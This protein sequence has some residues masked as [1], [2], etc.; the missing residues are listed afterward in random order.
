MGGITD[1]H[2]TIIDEVR[3]IRNALSTGSYK[4]KSVQKGREKGEKYRTEKPCACSG[5]RGRRLPIGTSLPP[6]MHQSDARC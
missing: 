5:V 4:Y 6:A 3:A 1:L 2:A